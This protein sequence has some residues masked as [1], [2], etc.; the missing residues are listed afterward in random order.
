[1]DVDKQTFTMAADSLEE[2]ILAVSKG[3]YPEQVTPRAVV[4]VHLYGQPADMRAIMALSERYG[5]YVIEDCA[6]AHGAS[7]LDRKAGTWGHLAA[8]SFYPTKNLGA[9]GDGG[10]VVTNDCAL[11]EKLR[12]LRQYGWNE[13][14]VSEIPGFNSRLDELQ[15][16]ILRVKL[17]YLDADNLMRQEI[18]GIYGKALSGGD[19]DLPQTL[20]DRVHVYHQYVISTSRRDQ[21]QDTSQRPRHWN[22]HP[23]PRA[24]SP[25]AGLSWQASRQRNR[26]AQ[27]RTPV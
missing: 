26:C 11:A 20:Q 15:A 1:M 7:F 12:I 4:P 19:I 3:L 14:R 6:Q 17:K 23:L 18:A 25:P 13:D 24:G 22:S 5:L 9:L 10:A 16:A 8:F 2:A 21:L 27:H